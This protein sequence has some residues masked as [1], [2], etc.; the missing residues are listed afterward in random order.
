M[1]AAPALG[2]AIGVSLNIKSLQCD[3]ALI[4]RHCATPGAKK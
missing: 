4:C 2:A 1:I 3:E